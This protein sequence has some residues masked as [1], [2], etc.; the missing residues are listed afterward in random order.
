MQGEHVQY[1]RSGHVKTTRFAQTRFDSAALIAPCFRP[2]AQL[3]QNK[4]RPAQIKSDFGEST[5]GFQIAPAPIKQLSVA[6]PVKRNRSGNQALQ[7]AVT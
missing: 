6:T 2:A 3:G 5:M 4:N 7:P 1:S